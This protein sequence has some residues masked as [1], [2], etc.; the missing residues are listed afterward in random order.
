[1]LG[2]VRRGREQGEGAQADLVLVCVVIAAF[3]TLAL[4]AFFAG[5]A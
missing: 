3:Q 1:M 4:E 5:Q 2:R